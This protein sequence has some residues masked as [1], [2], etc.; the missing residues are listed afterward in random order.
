MPM[1]ILPV[2]NSADTMLEWSRVQWEIFRRKVILRSFFYERSMTHKQLGA[3][4]REKLSSLPRW[5]ATLSP[6]RTLHIVDRC[7]SLRTYSL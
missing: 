2:T 1:K 4:C 6:L 7:T 3:M 5:W